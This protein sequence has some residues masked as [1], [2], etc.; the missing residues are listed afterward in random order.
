[1]PI[2]PMILV[3]G[4]KANGTGYSTYIP[5]YSPRD[6]AEAIKQKIDRK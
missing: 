6:L 3:N 2:I 5:S 1:M 4:S